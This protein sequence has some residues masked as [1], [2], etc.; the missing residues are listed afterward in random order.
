MGRLKSLFI[1]KLLP[2][3]SNLEEFSEM[4][5]NIISVTIKF[6]ILNNFSHP[7]K[8]TFTQANTLGVFTRFAENKNFHLK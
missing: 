1:T 2:A 6:Q 5:D 4:T 7:L 8:F 3:K